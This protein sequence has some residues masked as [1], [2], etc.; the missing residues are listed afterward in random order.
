MM[1]KFFAP[2]AALTLAALC[3]AVADAESCRDLE[4]EVLEAL[5]D[6]LVADLEVETIRFRRQSILD[7]QD[8]YQSDRLLRHEFKATTLGLRQAVPL[9]E[10]ADNA[11][12]E[13]VAIL[14]QR[15]DDAD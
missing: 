12:E 6:K 2:L 13:A 5:H 7:W 3:P 11:Y 8:Q 4:R 10:Q 1:T 9:A 15:C 14:A